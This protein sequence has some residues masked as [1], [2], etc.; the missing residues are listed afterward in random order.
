MG[1]VIRGDLSVMRDYFSARST[2]DWSAPLQSVGAILI[3]QTQR[4][5]FSEKV[6]PSGERWPPWSPRYARSRHTN[7]S[8]LVSEG[9]LLGS[10]N[11]VIEKNKVAI[12]SNLCYAATHQ[13]GDQRRRI[14]RRAYLGVSLA[15][16]DK[17]LGIVL[18]YVELITRVS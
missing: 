11:T 2:I 4:R 10:L 5:I 6:S 13:Y 1:V 14:P 16:H 3:S 17:I 7:Q 12:G 8:L 18:K 15:D 9:Y